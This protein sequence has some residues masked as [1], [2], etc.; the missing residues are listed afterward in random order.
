MYKKWNFSSKPPSEFVEL[1]QLASDVLGSRGIVD[2]RSFFSDTTAEFHEPFL[3]KDMDK[4]VTLIKDALAVGDKITVFGDYDCDGVTST[5]M[6][7]SYLTALGSEVAWYV[8]TRDEGYGLNADAV[9]QIA[10]NGTKLLITVDNGVSAVTEAELIAQ[11]GMKLL[12]TDHHTVPE[13]LPVAEAIINPKQRDCPYPCKTL[14][15]CGVVLKLIAALE[16][17]PTEDV[18]EQYGDLAAIGTVADVVE[19]KDEN[20]SIVLHGLRNIAYSESVGL[21]CLFKAAGLADA[22]ENAENEPISA[23][24]V[25]FMVAPRINAAGRFADAGKA[26]ELLLCEN[27]ELAAAKAQE[28]SAFNNQRVEEERRILEQVNALIAAAP[29]LLNERVLV[30][31]GDKWHHGVIGIIASRMVTRF[32]KPCVIITTDGE[33]AKGSARSVGDFSMIGALTYCKDLLT[34]FGGHAGAGGFSL[35]TPDIASFK[36]RLS[37]YAAKEYDIMPAAQ[38]TADSL[39]A[40]SALT[41]DNIEK[42]Q[43]IAPFGEGNPTPV[44][45]LKGC[46]LVHKRP[47]KEGKYILFTVK[48]CDAE[49]KVLDFTRAYVDFWYKVGDRVDLMVNIDINEYNDTKSLSIKVIDMRLAALNWCDSAVQ[50]RFFAAAD[51]YEKLKRDER[52]DSKLYARIIPTDEELKQVYGIIKES[53]CLDQIVQRA[54]QSGLNYCKARV[55]ADVF[56]EA[57][58]IRFDAA[59]GEVMLNQVSEKADLT[60]S[61]L[62]NKLRA[63]LVSPSE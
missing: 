62:L 23:T 16:S 32:G 20:R 57:G 4:A 10:Q 28:L 33:T 38:I 19:L 14:A 39:P 35:K 46:D 58:L 9:T 61:V 25:A 17:A 11:K 34:R 45:C 52:L 6:L 60:K 29:A 55:I 30:L 18:L 40:P 56:E 26:V 24:A 50:T 15:G 42:L 27:H 3:L 8:P 13:T 47:L 41:V 44:F 53:F 48:Y 54:A 37:E 22:L 7:Y 36:A 49:F 51:A 31:S 59:K 21:R 63:C 43:H 2:A 12:I 5:V 1:G